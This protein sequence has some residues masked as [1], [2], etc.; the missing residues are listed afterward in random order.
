MSE[1]REK[2]ASCGRPVYVVEVSDI[3][4]QHSKV[5]HIDCVRITTTVDGGKATNY[6]CDNECAREF[7]STLTKLH[8]L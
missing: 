4:N 8:G 7:L 5:E 3:G 2:C 6:V 1:T